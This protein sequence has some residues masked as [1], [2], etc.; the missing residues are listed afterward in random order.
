M[1]FRTS[2][3]R[4][5]RREDFAGERYQASLW[6]PQGVDFSGKTVGI[7]GTDPQAFR[8]FLHAEQAAHLH[9]FQRTPNFS[10]PAANALLDAVGLNH[11]SRTIA[12][13][14]VSTS[15]V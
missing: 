1:S 8:R 5:Y 6:P 7:I 9:V 15:W 13:I 10:V 3:T 14:G 2:A 12:I 11:L 4:Y